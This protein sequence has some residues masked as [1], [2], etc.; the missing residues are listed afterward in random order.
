MDRNAAMLRR[1]YA[2]APLDEVRMREG[3]HMARADMHNLLES[4]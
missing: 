2:D 1:S 4:L 3:L